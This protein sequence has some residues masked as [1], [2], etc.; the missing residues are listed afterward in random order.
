MKKMK[1]A[2]ITLC[3]AFAFIIAAPSV[4]QNLLGRVTV[5]AASTIKMNKSAATLYVGKSVQLKVN[6]TSKKAK[7]NSSNKK[8]ATVSQTGKV[9]AKKT[10]KSTITAKV[11]N[12]T[13]K[14]VVTVKNQGSSVKTNIKKLKT[15]ISKNGS[16]NDSG[17]KFIKFSY[18]DN[19]TQY[20]FGIVYEKSKSNLKFLYFNES[21]LANSSMEMNIKTD[22]KG[23]I[24]SQ[25]ILEF[26]DDD[27]YCNAKTSFKASSYKKNS[28]VYFKVTSGVNNSQ[29]QKLANTELRLAFA[30]WNILVSDAGLKLR[31]IGFTSYK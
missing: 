8:V 11:G 12:K 7:W 3:L 5:E 29:F 14:C 19:G 22:N 4:F 21:D 2:I 13:A 6:G 26:N 30:G 15:Y 10:G 23:N 25:Y 28:T 9:T 27:I 20:T 24:T 18:S 1:K 17:N 16:V 31:D